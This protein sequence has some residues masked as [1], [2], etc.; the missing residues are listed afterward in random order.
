MPIPTAITDLSAT[1]G[2]NSPLG[3]ESPTEGDN[4]I[5]ALSAIIRQEHD[6]LT[7]TSSTQG[8][9]A[10]PF[11]ASI[12][13]GTANTMGSFIWRIYK[14]T[15]AEVTAGVTP[16]YYEFPPGDVRR[17][18]ADSTGATVSK[19]AF[20]S[21]F[22]ANKR[23]AIPD[24]TW[25]MGTLAD[26]AAAVDLTALGD[27][28]VIDTGPGA[29][30]KCTT[31]GATAI[32]YFFSLNNNNDFTCGDIAF[33]DTAGD[34]TVT[35]KGAFGF[36]V[37]NSTG[38]SWGNIKISSIKATN[39]V[40]PIAVQGPGEA[41]NRIRG[42]HIGQMNLT[43]CYY[44]LSL[45]NEGDGVVVDQIIADAC[46]RPLFVYGVTGVRAK[47]FARN[48]RA[49]SGAI[50]ISRSAGGLDTRGIYVDYSTT[51]NSNNITHV[52]INHIDLLGGEITD[53]E[54][55]M[56]IDST[57][58]FTPFRLV[59]Y[60][61]ASAETA[62]ASSNVVDRIRI[63]GWIDPVTASNAGAAVAS[64]TSRGRL[65]LDLNSSLYP[66][67]T[68][69]AA[70]YLGDNTNGSVTWSATG[71]QP[72]LGNGALTQSVT[73]EGNT[74]HTITS[75]QIGSTT[76]FGTGTW[77][78][79]VPVAAANKSTA[80]VYMKDNSVGF[81]YI[82]IAI[83]EASATTFQIYR[84]GAAQISPTVPFTWATDDRIEVALSY[85]I[86]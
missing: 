50:N 16:T 68:L 37:Q 79:S 24:G 17:Y 19:T 11:D 25:D 74:L 40:A 78:F 52:I 18:G 45:Q 47:V 51:D 73:R 1:P 59:N 34:P 26:G 2:S 38:Q 83:I 62:A 71:T 27:G 20:Q 55:N 35:W 75:L 80:A 7:G 23:V 46:I 15:A 31:T 12:T 48:N 6:T 21:C 8:A 42:I 36:Y 84:D 32:P 56:N 13:Y 28:F 60:N 39:L 69:L 77:L 61:G 29:L 76:T 81:F 3:S 86:A 10:V 5:R 82:G 14:R 58:I 22:N 72:V 70:M 54:V 85:R 49:T 53:V 57:S 30:M 4:Y 65:D 67:A 66:D 63:K 44:G 41:A 64:Y 33:E 43:D 9:A